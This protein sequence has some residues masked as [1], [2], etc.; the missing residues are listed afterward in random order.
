[1]ASF[2]TDSGS[3][4]NGL[5]SR[6]P[7]V[8]F[9][10]G[11]EPT[12]CNH[13]RK[14]IHQTARLTALA[15]LIS[16]LATVQAQS[17]PTPSER[18]GDLASGAVPSFRKHVIPLLGVRGC[19]GRE[20]HGSFAGKG[21]FQLSLFGYDFDKDHKE[22]TRDEDEIRTDKENPANSLILL[23]PTMQEKHKGKLRFKKGSWEY[24]LL[25]TW[26]KNGAENDAQSTPEFDRLEVQPGSIEFT[27]SNQT[28]QL[29]VIAH[30]RDGTAEDVT[31]LTRFRTNDES[32]AGVDKKG[33]V[34]AASPGDTHIIAFYD[35]GVQP[36]PVYRPVSKK[37]G[38]DYPELTTSTKVDELVAA[39]LR[40]LGII[41]SA[42]CTD[43][44]FLR[45]ISLDV[46]GSLPLPKEIRSFVANRSPLKRSKKIDELLKRPAYAAWWTTK[47]CDYTGNNP[48]NQTDPVF[49][50][51][52]AR[53][54]YEWI[55]H[56]VRTN[57]P[58]DQIA[59]GLIM[60]TSRQKGESFMQF[61]K[62]MSQHYKTENPIP[63]HTR[64]TMP[65]YWARRNVRQAQE[66]ALSFAHAFLGVRIQC[67][68]CHK[69]P[70]DQWTQQDFKKF[71]AFF[72]PI[73]YKANTPKAEKDDKGN[74]YQ[75]L[76]KELEQFVGYDKEKK[77]NKKELRAEIKRRAQAGQPV[78]WQELYIVNTKAKPSTKKSNNKKRRYNGRVITPSVLGGEDV[79]LT[80][81]QDPRQPLMDWLR[82]DENPYF[83][84]AFIN[85]V[86]HNYFGHGIVEPV[87]DMNL[88]NPPSNEPL[89][90]YLAKGFVESGHD[91]KWLHRTILSSDAYQRSWKPN[92]TNLQDERNFSRMVVRRLPAEV[93]ADAI[94]QATASNTRVTAMTSSPI[95]R[96]IGPDM[97][98]KNNKKLTSMN[99]ALSV[100]GKPDR[101]ENCDC[102]RSNA[103]TLLQ[104]VFTRNDPSLISMI[105]GSD[106]RA[107]GW[108]TE[109]EEWY[110]GKT[111]S[112]KQANGNKRL[113]QLN[114]QRKKLLAKVPKKP[115]NTQDARATQRYQLT[116]KKHR[117]AVQA[118]N[119]NI[120][121][122]K[123]GRSNGN[124]A[125]RQITA[126][127]T[128][129][130]INETFLRTVS[131]MPSANE[132]NM[133]RADINSNQDK[134][135]GVKDLLWTLLNTKEF[136]VN[137]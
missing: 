124:L 12:D 9:A 79:H 107:K 41:P 137:H 133:A 121:K 13:L 49:R 54:W 8:D 47:L 90:D 25:L 100:F 86:W 44:E 35:N 117:E 73:Q 1:M 45:R 116:I 52:M 38:K 84:R 15:C 6:K 33:L 29:Q 112:T 20:C 83:A 118:L 135:A 27:N 69:H 78:P 82:S 56:R 119:R 63:F 95:D 85:R 105:N 51:E 3:H 26:I 17:L 16:T 34:S 113:K 123:G 125:K 104:S 28:R 130:L 109:V 129:K 10:L 131:R 48:Q 7:K 14:M 31:E 4:E 55:Y 37:S 88:A 62:G 134:I 110:S 61:A 43:E 23:K 65:F 115:R 103:P 11:A 30:W 57:V 60:A 101:T 132:L 75:S 53:N 42:Q 24:Q 102:E 108:I 5:H 40:K 71:Q 39:K 59:E 97:L 19:N 74:N 68:Q 64:E 67:A 18:F 106:R 120:S 99:Y 111:K 127:E 21:D 114:D 76:M 70:F 122:L 89:L 87:D 128:D 126:L 50:N 80:D 46:T 94:T 22:I 77:N 81:Y 58:Y 66:K 96:T 2:N 93:V 36:V 98:T 136:L 32:I 72:E 92:E 91:M